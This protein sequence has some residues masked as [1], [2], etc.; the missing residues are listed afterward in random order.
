MI[1]GREF[2]SGFQSH[3]DIRY[4]ALRPT[5]EIRSFVRQQ[6]QQEPE[7][8]IPSTMS[9]A[10]A[11]KL[12]KRLQ[13]LTDGASKESIQTLAKWIGFNRKYS[14]D[15]TKTLVTALTGPSST[16]ARRWLY[17]QI[18]HQ[19]LRQELN[20]GSKWA[21]LEGLRV[22][23]GEH[24][25]LPLFADALTDEK[26]SQYASQLKAFLKEWD[27]DNVFGGPTMVNLTKRSMMTAKTQSTST[28]AAAT[29]ATTSTASATETESKD[30]TGLDKKEPASGIEITDAKQAATNNDDDDDFVATVE[31][32]PDTPMD[33]D[34]ATKEKNDDD[35]NNNTTAEALIGQSPARGTPSERRNSATPIAFDF[36][37]QGI[38]AGPVEARDFQEPCRAIATLQIARDLRSETTAR[39]PSILSTVPD[40]VWTLCDEHEKNVKTNGAAS[41]NG[42]E[43]DRSTS[44]PPE[45][46]E[47][48]SVELKP[49]LL[50][51]NVEET[52]ENVA[53]LKQL[54]LKMRTAR[55]KL[56]NLLIRSRCKFGADDAAADFHGLDEK[57]NQLQRRQLLVADAME[58]EALD[59]SESDKKIEDDLKAT[60][61]ATK[62]H[63]LD[64]YQASNGPGDVAQ[65][66]AAKRQ[67]V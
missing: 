44:L 65:Q 41:M 30:S 55:K 28:D 59:I 2:A 47:K 23:L 19:V 4:W 54:A 16:G 13:A 35:G 15:F 66:G 64:W 36:E 5:G 50:D 37:S 7:A 29:D 26:T 52:L 57:L 49:E 63:S 33:V 27:N 10:W 32:T 60:M 61:K 48:L 21:R 53:T 3:D 22:A 11:G 62:F 14:Q 31:T 45:T 1:G 40:H 58:L 20:N 18:V 39:L 56:A 17:W 24:V 6:S 25:V 8:N 42:D 9:S 43:G 67:K 51:L 12:E 38:P 46:I 34:G